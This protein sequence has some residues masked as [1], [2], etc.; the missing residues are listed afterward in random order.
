[1]NP[2]QAHRPSVYEYTDYRGYLRDYYVAEK[3]QRPAFSY[4]YFA[5]RAGHSS[6]NFLKLVIE[7]N[8]NLGPESVTAFSRALEL[9]TEEAGFFADL[10]AYGQAKTDDLKAKHL[11]RITAAR[12]YR[13]AGRIEGQLFDYLAHWYL[14]AIRELVARPD[15]EE[16]PK[17]IAR[18]LVPHI[19]AR[20]AA[21]G[22]KVLLNLGL[23][24]RL[25]DGRLE[26]GDPSWTTGPEANSKI[27]ASFHH[28]MLML[29]AEAVQN[30]SSEERNITSLVVCV[31]AKTME[32]IRRRM[33]AFQQ[34]LLALC[35][36]DDEP[37]VVYQV[38]MQLFPLSRP[39]VPAAHDVRQSLPRGGSSR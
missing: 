39:R 19:S 11:A 5:R 35:D 25:A 3:A 2:R 23:V 21:D 34:E 14:P 36:S 28:Q 15:F 9:D 29:A 33:T 24:R 16:D 7:G 37:E 31:R 26:R 20:R 17:W 32:E 12:N 30:F 18:E 1:M 8:R 6:P 27:V 13:K 4:R 38:G 10:V 22:L